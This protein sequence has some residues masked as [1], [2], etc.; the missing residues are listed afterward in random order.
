MDNFERFFNRS[1]RVLS[2]RP[3][4][5]KEIIDFLRRPRGRKKNRLDDETIQKI[6][7]KLKSQGLVD[8]REFA[9]WWIEQRTQSRRPKGIRIVKTELQQR[10]VDRELIEK[11]LGDY[12]IKV[13]SENAVKRLVTKQYPKYAKLP[14]IEIRQKLAQ[15]LLRRGFDWEEVKNIVDEVLKK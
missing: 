6:L 3:R 12:D 10:G 1:L 15:F 7:N 8:D 14:K 2:Y 5:E 9:K 11:I 13:L 4:S